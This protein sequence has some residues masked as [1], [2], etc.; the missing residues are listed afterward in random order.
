MKQLLQVL[1]RIMLIWGIFMLMSNISWAYQQKIHPIKHLQKDFRQLVELMKIH[2]QLNTFM[3]QEAWDELIKKQY[4]ALSSPMTTA[5]FHN[6]CAPVIAAIRCGHSGMDMPKRFWQDKTI[7]YFPLNARLD[8]DSMITIRES[9]QV[10]AK[11]ILTQING[12]PISEIIKG[13]KANMHIDGFNQYGK[14]ARINANFSKHLSTF[15]NFPATYQ[16][17][18]IDPT[19]TL[20]NM[21]SVKAKMLQDITLPIR[22][23]MSTCT[24]NL[25]MKVFPTQKAML[26]TVK[27]FSYYLDEDL[28]VFKH[29]VDSCFQ[30]IEKKGLKVN[31]N[32]F[33]N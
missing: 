28:E 4:E 17:S 19:T 23:P 27:S 12:K 29:F 14:E 3:S 5:E 24:E 15:L 20:E 2:P 33:K 32:T 7:T 13:M 22:N 25:C 1:K 16:I 10:P 31:L 26:M 30:S 18:Y 8:G 21:I 6:I 9:N 11:S